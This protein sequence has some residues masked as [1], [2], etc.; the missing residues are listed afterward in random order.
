M[1]LNVL[2]QGFPCGSMVKNLPANAGDI[3]DMGSV[4]ELGRSPWMSAWQTI[5]VFLPGEFSWQEDPGNLEFKGSQ[6][7]GQN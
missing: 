7:V 2:G 5:P 3:R 1:P 6:R 4:P